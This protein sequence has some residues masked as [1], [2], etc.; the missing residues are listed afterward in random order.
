MLSRLPLADVTFT[1]KK[2]LPLAPSSHGCSWREGGLDM[3]WEMGVDLKFSAMY[4][5]YGENEVKNPAQALD[6]AVPISALCRINS[7]ATGSGRFYYDVVLRIGSHLGSTWHPGAG[8][9]PLPGD[10][11]EF[12]GFQ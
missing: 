6:F 7:E 11:A 5:V 4:A 9:V 10:S 12:F 2:R 8:L 3:A 1:K